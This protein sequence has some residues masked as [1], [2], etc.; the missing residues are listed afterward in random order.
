MSQQ[1]ATDADDPRDAREFGF[2]KADFQRVRE[3]VK[4]RAGIDL[5]P[6]K[7]SLVYGRLARRV[8][9][10]GLPTFQAYLGVVEDAEGDEAREFINALTTNVTEF[11]R[12]NHHF[13]F[14]TRT[15]LPALW[16]RAEGT[17]RR[18]RFWSAGCS[19]GEEP[20]S[21]AMV[22]RESMPTSPGWDIKIL[23]TDLDTDVLA[24]A[25]RGVYAGDRVEKIS[26]ARKGRF[27]EPA[28]PGGEL[29]ASDQLRSLITFKQ[30]NL[31]EPWPM[32]GPFDVIFCRNVVIYFDEAT[33]TN[34]V[35]RYRELLQSDGLLFLG[36][37]ESLV[38]TS[39]GF[40]PSGKTI[41][42]KVAAGARR[43]A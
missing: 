35:R 37:S 41:Y 5:G 30:L 32:R 24:H 13:D 29:R 19:T 38:S 31:M 36:H 43:A 33:K 15:A 10:L 22:V 9:A 26:P 21:L 12:E 18:V 17:G 3:L 20:Y 40:E 34:L 42:R 14:L 6:Q 7:Q 1:T 27:F 16:K 8:R 28:G 39:L 25:A 23:A 4:A 2:T 11:F